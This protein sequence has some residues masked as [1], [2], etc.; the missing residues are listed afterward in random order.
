MK[1]TSLEP[2]KHHRERLNLY[3]DGV[4]R[5][6]LE[7][8]AAA[9]VGFYEGKEVSE[10]DLSL[11]DSEEEYQKCMN[12][13][14]GLV[15]RRLQSEREYWQKLGKKYEKP[16]IGRCLDRLRELGY[17]D[18][19]KFAEMW[20][21]ERSH[22]RGEKLLRSELEQKGIAKAILDE[23]LRDRDRVHD[24]DEAYQ[25]AIKKYK[26]DDTRD[27]NYNRIAGVL[28]RKGYDYDTIKT[29]TNKILNKTTD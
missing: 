19:T 15:S 27:K 10:A 8:G 13:A 28:G 25:V 11:L 4:F 14:L 3:I 7:L 20:I 24:K 9:K 17:A 16:V 5:C 12:A 21:R 29:I 2:Q 6:G 23:L 18:D 26:P 1:I 22:T